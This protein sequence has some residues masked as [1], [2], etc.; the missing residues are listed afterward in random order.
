MDGRLRRGIRILVNVYNRETVI[1]SDQ[2]RS[3]GIRLCRIDKN[4]QI[5]LISTRCD[6]LVLLSYPDRQ[7][8]GGD[9]LYDIA[10]TVIAAV[11][12]GVICHY[13]IKWLD[14]GKHDN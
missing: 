7:R 12:G 5:L 13:I 11:V 9:C 8:E 3:V 6:M 2:S 10:V 14:S 1:R 4:V